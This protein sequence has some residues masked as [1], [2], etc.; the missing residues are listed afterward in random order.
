MRNDSVR[1]KKDRRYGGRGE[2]RRRNAV[3]KSTGN[4]YVFTE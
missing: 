2:N 3:I 1:E 4:I